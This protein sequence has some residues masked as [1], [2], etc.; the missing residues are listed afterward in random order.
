M[1]SVSKSNQSTKQYAMFCSFCFHSKRPET[2]FS[3]HWVKNKKDGAV[4]CPLLLANVC[5]YCKGTGHTPKHCPRLASRD[6]RRKTHEQRFRHQRPNV[7]PIRGLAQVQQQIHQKEKVA[8][9][10]KRNK[11]VWP[12]A[13]FAVLFRQRCLALFCL[14]LCLLLCTLVI[15]TARAVARCVCLGI[16]EQPSPPSADSH[17]C[18]AMYEEYIGN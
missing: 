11:K 7:S 14:T 10:Q 1:A 9:Q 18:Q 15:Q 4:C 12:N 3:S 6:Q 5:G 8:A 2:E 16:A 13:G 17:S